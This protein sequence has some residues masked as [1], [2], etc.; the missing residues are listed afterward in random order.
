MGIGLEYDE[1]QESK[2][3]Y[4]MQ[5]GAIE[6]EEPGNIFAGVLDLIPLPE[7]V[8][9][10]LRIGIE[11]AL[12]TLVS[13][14]VVRGINV[15][16]AGLVGLSL[17]SAAMVP[18]FN[19]ILA[20]N[21]ERIWAAPGTGR[22]ANTQSAISGISIFGGMFL[23]FLLMAIFAESGGFKEDFAFILK[24]TGFKPGDILS[25]E[26]FA[27]GYE[28]IVHNLFVLVALAILALLYRSL[29]TMIALGWNASVWAITFALFIQGGSGGDTSQFLHT[30]IVIVAVMPHLIVEA[31]GYV[32]GALS[33]VFLSRGIMR[34]EYSDP[35]LR[36]VLTAVLVLAGVS[37]ALII[38][39]GLM[40]INY[41]PRVLGLAQ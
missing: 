26:R 13:V 28:V 36:R 19:T 32:I 14:Y 27:L 4:L 39:G 10:N 20:T 18:R 37:V 15:P 6:N 2:G 33:G 41:A 31:L 9:W 25:P 7:N 12:I 5:D 38:V 3:T 34:Y 17:A 30:V 24:E 16:E 35:R 1:S 23:G 21:R 11:G 8:A 22:A 29:G 40:E